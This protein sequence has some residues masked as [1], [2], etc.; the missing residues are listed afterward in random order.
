MREYI[1]YVLRCCDATYYL[2]I[3]NNLERRISEHQD[4][5]D[6]SSFTYRRRLVV[7]VYT[8]QFSEIL[9]AIA[10]E[11]KVKRWSRTKKEALIRGAFEDLP[12]LAQRRTIFRKPRAI[13]RDGPPCHT[14]EPEPQRG[15]LAVRPAG[16]LRMT[17]INDSSITNSPRHT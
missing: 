17:L 9:D 14:E 2:G 12:W 7:L 11:K 8:A 13:R 1:V 4:G 10:W 3:T 16:L 15:R 5:C 6:S